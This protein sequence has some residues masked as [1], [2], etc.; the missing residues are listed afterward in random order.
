MAGFGENFLFVSD[1]NLPD[2]IIQINVL[3]SPFQKIQRIV[4]HMIGTKMSKKKV[5]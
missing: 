5:L 4:L 1:F 3:D 2:V